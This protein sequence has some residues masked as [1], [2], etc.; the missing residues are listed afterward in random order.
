VSGLVLCA[1]SR[2][3]RRTVREEAMFAA[4]PS[5]RAVARAVPDRVAASAARRLAGLVVAGECEHELERYGRSFDVHHVLDA[6]AALGDF[7]SFEWIGSLDV[8]SAVLVHLRDHVVPPRRQFALA[9]A[10]PGCA[11]HA[12]DG[13]HF[14]VTRKSSAFVATLRRAIRDVSRRA[15]VQHQVTKA[16]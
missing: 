16:S 4:L 1:T 7:R 13:D 15:Q 14:A 5:A 9:R 3:F 12:V 10:I 8:P 11:V 6:A 2:N